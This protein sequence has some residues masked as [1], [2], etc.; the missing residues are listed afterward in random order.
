MVSEI[1]CSYCSF[2]N[3]PGESFCENCGAQLNSSQTASAAL[4][5]Q[6][7]RVLNAL[8]EGGFGKVYKVEDKQLNNRLLAAKKLDFASIAPKDHQDAINSFKQEA[9]ILSDLRHPNLPRIYE[10][11]EE[12]NNYY[13]IMDFIEGKNLN[14]HLQGLPSPILPAISVANIGIQLA[15]VL[16]YL[17]TRQ[18]AI[19][20]RDLKPDN[21]MITF[22]EEIY[23][24]DFG[25][26]RHFKPGQAGDTIRWGTREY[27]APEQ[28]AGQQTSISSDIYSL[29]AVLHQLLSGDIPTY[30]PQFAPLKL[31][32]AGQTSL[33]QQVIHMLERD[34]QARP[35][36]M[37]EI[38]WELERIAQ[39][40]QQGT[41]TPGKQPPQTSQKA[42][43]AV[44]QPS[45]PRPKLQK[46]QPL[47]P[48]AC[49][50]LLHKYSQ[51]SSAIRAL[52]WSPDGDTLASAGEDQ[53]V[54]IWQAATG[55]PV[56]TYQNHTRTVNALAW[57]PDSQRLASAGNDH[58][59]QIWEANSGKSLLHYQEH[60]HWV[61]TLSWSSD[62]RLIASGDAANQVQLWDA[63]SGQQQRMYQG[64][65]G[66][67]LALAFS[68]DAR[69]IASA[70]EGGEVHIW[71]EASGKLLI[72][73]TGHQKPVSSLAW[74]PNGKR[75]VSG[76][77]DRT[78]HVWEATSG[79]QITTCTIHQRMV[80]AVAWSP[81]SDLIA[82]ASK[83]QTVQVWDASTCH[84]LLTYRGHTA[85]IN[86]LHWSPDGS[87]LASTGDDTTVHVWRAH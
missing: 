20:F 54:H 17:H 86:A 11:L 69:L 31:A 38:K 70:D 37:A 84:A 67:V 14:E 5:N 35:A 59:V 62:G 66:S 75:L 68:P 4:L 24:I 49:A 82:S 56:F 65:K 64:H 48:K 23:L 1:I 12:N 61:Q 22:K 73:Y 18:P 3:Q 13:L 52:A 7:Y 15:S 10:Y 57:S 45:A 36:S 80:N 34:K 71:E 74:S 79:K 50:D 33:G 41:S 29:G 46:P 85:N 55:K 30:P 28:L 72:T 2:S 27:A 26:A 32:G 60:R 42:Q 63:C 77:W 47:L 9:I 19:I 81:T 76:S 16:D 44:S 25:I 53:Q 78:L 58:S 87:Y 51:H 8:G 39:A 6:R 83:D 21:I 40:F 43:A